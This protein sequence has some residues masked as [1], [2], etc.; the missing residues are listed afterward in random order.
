MLA[1]VE[2]CK[3]N[4][5][6]CCSSSSINGLIFVA[7]CQIAQVLTMNRILISLLIC[8]IPLIS[9]A[10]IIIATSNGNQLKLTSEGEWEEVWET[11]PNQAEY[12]SF[13][14]PE[15]SRALLKTNNAKFGI[16]FNSEKWDVLSGSHFPGSGFEN[17]EF[18][19]SHRKSLAIGLLMTDPYPASIEKVI[20]RSLNQIKETATE[21][22]V[23]YG[24]VF[25]VNKKTVY[26]VI[27]QTVEH[28]IP[29]T[30]YNYYYSGDEGSVQFLGYCNQ[31]VFW[32]YEDDIKDL[33]NG[34]LVLN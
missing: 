25:S 6:H 14:L 19:F 17:F 27:L 11:L 4:L 28:G 10:Q 5:V 16:Q 21:L 30:Y 20:S 8:L 33:L 18:E 32:K 26:M 22:T 9:W 7:C 2:S 24:E 29:L 15:E 34:F 23:A 3:E 13:T 1:N 31:K 12:N